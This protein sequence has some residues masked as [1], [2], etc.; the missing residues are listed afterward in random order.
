MSLTYRFGLGTNDNGNVLQIT[1]NR[2]GNRTQNFMYDSLTRIQQA[3]TNGTNWGET[4]SPN[5]T[6]PGVPPTTPGI[7]A[8]GNLTNRSGVTGKTT[9][10]PLS[11]PASNQNRLTGFGYDAAG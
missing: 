2:D 4:F 10:E 11:A 9:Y 1:N 3:Y 8:W 5:A 6:S 7:D